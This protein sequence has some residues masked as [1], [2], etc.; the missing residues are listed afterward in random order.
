M[1]S[2]LTSTNAIFCT[3]EVMLGTTINWDKSGWRSS[4]ARKDMWVLLGSRLDTGQQS[5]SPVSLEGKRHGVHQTLHDQLGKRGDCPTVLRVGL[6]GALHAVLGPTIWEGCGDPWIHPEEGNKVEERAG[7]L[8]IFGLFNSEKRS[9]R[10][11][12]IAFYSFPQRGAGAGLFSRYP[13]E[14]FE[15]VP[16]RFSLDIEKHF[17]T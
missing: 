8:R 5:V 17:F 11:R 10:G 9:L 12:L 15:S 3:Y 14:Q 7:R 13:W 2:N 4:P 1:G 6:P 16:G